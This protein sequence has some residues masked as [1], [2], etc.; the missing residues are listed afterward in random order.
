M[1]KFNL[2]LAV[3]KL[4]FGNCSVNILLELFKLK[5]S[6]TLMLIGGQADIASFEGSLTQDFLNWLQEI[7]V[8]TQ[9]KHDRKKPTFKLW[10]LNGSLSSFSEDQY[11]FTFYELDSP[12]KTELNIV[13]NQKKLLVSSSYSKEVFESFGC[14]NVVHCPLGFDLSLIHI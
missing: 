8:S 10:H 11:L 4:S 12:T 7:A 1:A 9:A 2:E 13:K 5:E 14:S 3:N 6:P